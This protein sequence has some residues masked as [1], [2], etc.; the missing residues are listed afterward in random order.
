MVVW[1][2]SSEVM[3]LLQDA[4]AMEIRVLVHR[5]DCAFV[6]TDYENVE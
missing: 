2:C 4:E 5:G 3:S 6:E 1:M